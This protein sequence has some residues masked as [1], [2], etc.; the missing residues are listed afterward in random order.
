MS[1]YAQDMGF[2][3]ETRF[4]LRKRVLVTLLPYSM[5]T[6]L[7]II[8][9]VFDKKIYIIIKIIKKMCFFCILIIHNFIYFQFLHLL[10]CIRFYLYIELNQF[11]LNLDFAFSLN[12]QS[13][14]NTFYSL[15]ETNCS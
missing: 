4:S 2:S 1:Y 7:G 14:K 11:N 10:F 6:K 12:I 8:T 5:I 13:F 15:N 3:M 9:K